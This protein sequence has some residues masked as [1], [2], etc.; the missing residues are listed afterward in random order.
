MSK[1]RKIA[2]RPLTAFRRDPNFS[3][4]FVGG[5]PLLTPKQVKYLL[6]NREQI[7]RESNEII[8]DIRRELEKELAERRAE[9]AATA[10][11]S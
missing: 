11:V 2:G 8:A 1:E 3:G 4:A 7:E 6:E 9:R 10:P 5:P